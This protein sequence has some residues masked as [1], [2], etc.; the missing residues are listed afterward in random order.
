MASAIMTPPR[1]ARATGIAGCFSSHCGYK[2]NNQ[3]RQEGKQPDKEETFARQNEHDPV[4]AL[5][6]QPLLP[7]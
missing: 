5:F 1:P 4:R 6:G 2:K 7:Q 3:A